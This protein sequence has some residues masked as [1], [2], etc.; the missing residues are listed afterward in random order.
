MGRDGVHMASPI[1]I[2]W[3]VEE[4]SVA[5]TEAS[6]ETTLILAIVI[7]SIGACLILIML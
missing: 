4:D 1:S 5:E 6:L 7:V 3:E 2:E